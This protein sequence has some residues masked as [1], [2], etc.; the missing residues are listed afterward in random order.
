VLFCVDNDEVIAA[1]EDRPVLFFPSPG[2]EKNTD[3]PAKADW[4]IYKAERLA[5]WLFQPADAPLAGTVRFK[6]S[7]PVSQLTLPK[8]SSKSRQS[9]RSFG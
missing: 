2:D 5:P 9:G 7:A 6:F 1:L 8:P 3:F 4:F